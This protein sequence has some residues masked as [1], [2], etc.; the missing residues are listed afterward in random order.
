MFNLYPVDTEHKLFR[1]RPFLC[2]Y[3]Q[4]TSCVW[5]VLEY[6]MPVNQHRPYP[7]DIGRKL[8]VHKTFRRRPFLCK[9]VQF[10][11]WVCGVEAN[12]RSIFTEQL[13]RKLSIYYKKILLQLFSC[14]FFDILKKLFYIAPADDCFLKVFTCRISNSFNLFMNNVVKK[15]NIL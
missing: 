2:T 10:T 1:R 3:I 6:S 11:S 14:K 7:V 9:Y 4:F 8:N 5:G 13:F 15:S 12:V